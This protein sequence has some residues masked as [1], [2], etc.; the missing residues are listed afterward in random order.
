MA[1]EY[2]GPEGSG[3]SSD[4]VETLN[5]LFMRIGT[6][7]FDHR[8]WMLVGCA[9]IFL[10]SLI[11][12]S[13]T[14][15][16]MSFESFFDRTDPT[17]A[18]Y[19]QY[20]DDFGSDEVSY[21]LYR[22]P[23]FEYGPWNLEVMRKIDSLTRALQK[24]VPFVDQ[25]TS[26]T[27]VEFMESIPDGIK[28]YDLLEDFPINQQA[29]LAV[30]D[31]VLAKPMYVGGLVSRD[32]QYAAISIEMLKSSID[33]PDEIRLDP[34]GG[35]GLDNL[36][37]QV[38]GEKIDE[39]L[40][41]PEY[42]GIEFFHAGDVPFNA[43]YNRIIE[44]EVPYLMT[45]SFLVVGA[46]LFYFF[47]RPIGVLGPLAVVNVAL[48]VAVGFMGALDWK[49]DF[50][51]GM[52][53]NLLIAVGVADAVHI[54]SE[55]TAY[56]AQFGDRREAVRRTMY[57]VGTPCLLTSLTTAVGFLAMSISPIKSI[58]HMATYCAVGVLAAFLFTVT[59][60]IVFLSIGHRVPQHALTDAERS[61][62]KGGQAMRRVLHAVARFDLRH[63]VPI[64]VVSIAICLFS[65]VG[66]FKLRVD[67]NFLTELS[68]KVPIRVVTQFVD[69]TMGGT[70]G[71]VY[72]FDTKTPDGIMEP[73]L[74]HE[75]EQLQEQ[76]DQHTDMVQKTYSIVDILKDLNQSFHEG[77]PAHYV[78]PDSRELIAQYLLIYSMSGGEEAEDYVSSD[79]SRASLVVRTKMVETSRIA[80]LE[81]SLHRFLNTESLDGSSVQITGIG[82]LWLRLVEYITQSQIRGII[83]AFTV[84]SAMMCF[85]FKS[86]R[87][88]MLSM[89]PNVAPVLLTLGGMGWA[90]MPLDYTRLLISTV[91]IGIAVDD[92]I[93][94]TTR[95]HHAFQECGNYEQALL[96][97]MQDVGRALFMT[98]SILI[99]GFLVNVASVMNS[100]A[101]FGLLLAATILVALLA[102]FLLMPALVLVF[103]PFGP[104]RR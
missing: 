54:I 13:R 95:F 39:I 86:I 63:R 60:L 31:K 14:R 37:P 97:S 25:V 20:R 98:S 88:G 15:I 66:L 18:A 76:A 45:I 65:T 7:S 92:T 78:L 32:A 83:L 90:G 2:P 9:L 89:V 81:R 94:L 44:K 69:E 73:S 68:T 84:I 67:S 100:Q 33:S 71:L 91:A 47:R 80:K 79:Y 4:Y 74:L 30:R 17:Y 77:D 40:A 64:L 96:D 21:I 61:R 104:E 58:A 19:L 3:R 29:L 52:L 103:K 101:A 82:A 75:I 16:D 59:L 34:E 72:L 56:H 85:I 51:F 28:I 102:D 1:K 70:I 42:A 43:A 26:L 53:P 27:N 12:A 55:F 35:D 46:L 48:A 41:R 24:E 50:M 10:G 57:L 87:I 6:W 23:S 22:A 8:W 93:H 62:S 99:A 5:R 38:T 49:I 11:L 36:Y